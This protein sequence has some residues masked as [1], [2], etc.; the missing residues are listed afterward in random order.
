MKRIAV[1]AALALTV[2]TA[3]TVLQVQAAENDKDQKMLRHVV[4]FKFADTAGE[5]GVKEIVDAF[6]ALEGKI[7]L[8]KDFEWGTNV[9][10]EGLDKGLTHGFTLTF[11]TQEDLDAYIVHEAHKAFVA[12]LNGRV[13]D[14]CVFDYWAQ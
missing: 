3:A 6:V 14:V 11:A 10:K 1:V 8:I 2:I 12:N 7:D 4:L 9:S 13:A 5:A